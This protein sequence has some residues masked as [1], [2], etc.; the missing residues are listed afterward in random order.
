MQVLQEVFCWKIIYLKIMRMLT[1]KICVLGLI[2]SISSLQTHFAYYTML[3]GI[4][5]IA[6]IGKQ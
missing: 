3:K 5:Q 2:S 6:S 1:N 4:I